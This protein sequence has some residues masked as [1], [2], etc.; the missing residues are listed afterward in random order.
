MLH[1]TRLSN[2]GVSIRKV[3]ICEKNL[4]EFVIHLFDSFACGMW[5]ESSHSILVV[6]WPGGQP[7]R[8]QYGATTSSAPLNRQ[9]A[10]DANAP[11]IFP[12]VFLVFVLKLR[13]LQQRDNGCSG[14]RRNAGS[15]LWLCARD[16]RGAA[17]RSAAPPTDQFQPRSLRSSSLCLERNPGLRC[18]FA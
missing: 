4:L 11:A 6:T 5:L 17:D 2:E 3:V 9:S 1:C 7:T 16:L 13:H 12:L 8:P 15:S 14:K 18:P 10:G